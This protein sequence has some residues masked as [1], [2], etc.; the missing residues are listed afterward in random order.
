M[1]A[2]RKL[3]LAESLLVALPFPIVL[4]ENI[5]FGQRTH[6]ATQP[7]LTLE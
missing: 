6:W 5:R 2:M 1:M 7:K 3:V 4:L